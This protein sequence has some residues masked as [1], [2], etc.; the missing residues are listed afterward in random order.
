MKKIF[1]LLLFPLFICGCQ[2]DKDL[3]NLSIVNAMGIDL[4]DN[5]YEI[6]L[7]ILK[8]N[9]ND[10]NDQ[11]NLEETLVYSSKGKNISDALSNITLKSPKKL[12]FGHLE[13]LIISENIAKNDINEISDYFLRNEE[14]SKNF[15][16][17]LSKDD[18][19]KDILKKFK[20]DNSFPTGNILGSVEI[21]STIQGTTNNV[22][23]TKFMQDLMNVGINPII[24]VIKT[25]NDNLI[26]EDIGV[27]KGNVLIGYLDNKEN[28]GYNF[29]TDNIKSTTINYKCDTDKYISININNSKT[30]IESK[31]IN[32][33]P[34]INL[35]VDAT[36]GI[37][38]VNCSSEVDDL[39]KVKKQTEKEIKK[40]INSVLEKTKGEIKSDIFGFGNNIYIN[41][42]FYWKKIKNNWIDNYYSNL[43]VNTSVNVNLDDQGSI[44]ETVR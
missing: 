11:N 39:T 4:S 16:M 35:K 9:K 1:I 24:P 32:E 7:Q 34:I 23:F 30:K 13:L 19:P 26:I 10:S 28:I 5:K 43:Q 17:L 44:I 15:T 36:A 22:K 29:I 27:F 33:T 3:N 31:I 20:N 41:H 14:V 2:N 21:S 25:N 40:I 8:S 6:S 12:Y 38:E 37:S 18:T 42:Y